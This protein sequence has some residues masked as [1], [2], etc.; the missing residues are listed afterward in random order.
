MRLGLTTALVL[1]V[2]IGNSQWV[3]AGRVAPSLPRFG[4][5]H[6]IKNPK[7]P[8]CGF[9]LSKLPHWDGH[10]IDQS[11]KDVCFTM[12]GTDPANGG[13]TTMI[14]VSIIPVVIK[15]GD[16][17]FDPQQHT[18]QNG[19]NVI[20]NTIASPLFGS[21][22]FKAGKV[23][24]G[25]TQYA[26][27]FQRANFWSSVQ[28]NSAYHVL[29]EHPQVVA[30]LVIDATGF[31]EVTSEKGITV[32][33]V[34]QGPFA[35]QLNLYLLK[36]LLFFD[37]GVLPLFIS[38]NVYLKLP[39]RTGASG[40]HS[41]FGNTLNSYCLRVCVTYAYATY[42]DTEGATSIPAQ[43]VSTLSHEIAEWM[44]DP[45]NNN[46]VSCNATKG[47]LEVADPLEG[48]DK[49]KDGYG[50][51]PYKM[52]GFTYNLQ[53]LAFLPYFGAPRNTSVNGWTSFHGPK[54]ELSVCG[55]LPTN[56]MHLA[57]DGNYDDDSGFG[58]DGVGYGDLA[59][60]QGYAPP[61]GQALTYLDSPSGVTVEP[62]AG[63]NLRSS[64]S[65]SLWFNAS[66]AQAQH[67]SALLYKAAELVDSPSV[68]FSDRSIALFWV[69]GG[70]HSVYTLDGDTNQTICTDTNFGLPT[71]AWH[72]L[73]FTFDSNAGEAR[74]YVDAAL[75]AVCQFTP[76]RKLRTGNKTVGV[77]TTINTQL[78]DT[79]TFIGQIDSVHV[80]QSALTADQVSELFVDRQ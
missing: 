55:A 12:V 18:V 29:L 73:A 20:Q 76:G 65:V 5:A 7:L 44:D 13:V 4:F 48:E 38:Y 54:D 19:L 39:D 36:N 72:H 11:G 26:D 51:Y 45:F 77:G 52:S 37:S 47:S 35:R 31:G 21:Y 53:S 23:Q 69:P 70:I 75:E 56:A 24:L 46:V 30:P 14:P 22:P 41:V 68:G 64:L 60:Q 25:T 43:D 74:L 80:Y 28:Q 8:P 1:A 3:S 78:G 66:S 34:D 79:G 59:F 63:L 10:F 57:F 32:G 58:N 27:A 71:D 50:S 6:P 49:G 16:T 2:I 9:V 42:V 17:T 15:I 67:Y 40:Y 62:Q 33:I 61:S